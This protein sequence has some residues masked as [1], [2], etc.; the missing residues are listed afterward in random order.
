MAFHGSS[1][2]DKP[3]LYENEPTCG[4][5]LRHYHNLL[6]EYHLRVLER[7]GVV[8]D[9]IAGVKASVLSIPA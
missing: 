9:R 4:L 3:G 5:K 8:K 7:T 2:A 6:V 1:H